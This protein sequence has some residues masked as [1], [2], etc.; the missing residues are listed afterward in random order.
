MS[1]AQPRST[2]RRLLWEI[3]VTIL[4]V[5]AVYGAW[6]LQEARKTRA[7]D[8]Q[9]TAF[10]TELD[11]ARQ[12]LAK[13]T[14]S[15]ARGEARV[16]FETFASTIGPVYEI[17][18]AEAVN[19]AIDALLRLPG[20]R[21]VH[22]LEPGGRVIATTDRKLEAT[23]QADQRARWALDTLETQERSDSDGT[24]ELAGPLPNADPQLAPVLWLGYAQ[25]PLASP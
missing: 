6:Q 8:E 25:S 22:L 23:G 2:W 21:F 12:K 15:Q 5:G 14:A 17:G 13:T 3:A 11:T 4:L 20:I 18:G 24:F 16:V 1:T 9:A 10:R 19:Q 7:L